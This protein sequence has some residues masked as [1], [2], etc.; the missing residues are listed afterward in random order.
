MR[1]LSRRKHKSH[2][3]SVD[4]S[5][6]TGSAHEER[7]ISAMTGTTRPGIGPMSR[8]DSSAVLLGGGIGS[9]SVGG[10]HGVE[11]VSHS[12]HA[13]SGSGSTGF[14]PTTPVTASQYSYLPGAGG[15]LGLDTSAV[16]GPYYRP[17]R[18][19]GLQRA[20]GEGS[21]SD[22][23]SP[24]A[25]SRG[26]WGSEMWAAAGGAAGRQRSSQHS[27]H[28]SGGYGGTSG[29]GSGFPSGGPSGTGTPHDGMDTSGFQ[30]GGI[31]EGLGHRHTDSSLGG[32]GSVRATPDYAVREGDFYYG[33][34]GPALSS[35]PA[36]RLGTGPADPTGSVAVAKGWLMRKLG[37]AAR[38]EKGF[39][40]VRSSRAPEALLDAE[41]EAKGIGM[42]ISADAPI[43][44]DEEDSDSSD[45]ESGDEEVENSKGVGKR[46]AAGPAPD[47]ESE[48]ESEDENIAASAP[49]PSARMLEKQP[50]YDDTNSAGIELV[51][52][53]SLKP[54]V[55]RKSSK[56]KSASLLLTPVVT[57]DRQHTLHQ[58]QHTVDEDPDSP[59]HVRKPDQLYDPH[60]SPPQ[61]A[62]MYSQQQQLHPLRHKQNLSV[63]PAGSPSTR[64]PFTSSSSR[65]GQTESSAHSR[66]VST[67]SSILSPP[68]MNME[69]EPGSRP[70]SVGT[71][72]RFRME[73]SLRTVPGGD[74][75]LMGSRAELVEQSRTASM[76]S[77]FS[78]RGSQAS[79]RGV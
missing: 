68:Q 44:V 79:R 30:K 58:Q 29:E 77:Q 19:K 72:Q 71:V 56:R 8:S 39:T 70:A 4:P 64:L 69:Y 33:V 75:E 46:R 35:Q 23:Y 54:Q 11:A 37:L 1:Q 31:I 18:A 12:G 57:T 15:P 66:S 45:E 34:R 32:A 40:V 53:G 5:I 26:S 65:D 52:Q 3:G 73:D 38:E 13:H 6:M 25:R 55:P 14:T 50:A 2:H 36:R 10:G 27:S 24:G 42:A 49:G 60:Y 78:R 28:G 47:T 63:Q 9:G 61:S 76:G 20:N 22:N 62:D 21:A 7:K 43:R 41:R 74:R 51:R 16:A 48:S 67:T 59:I 17:P